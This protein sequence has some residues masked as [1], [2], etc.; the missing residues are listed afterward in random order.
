MPFGAIFQNPQ[1]TVNITNILKSHNQLT[2]HSKSGEMTWESTKCHLWA[3][4]LSIW[5]QNYGVQHS[6]TVLFNGLACR[7]TL[8]STGMIEIEPNATILY[9]CGLWENK[10][11]VWYEPRDI[12]HTIY[13]NEDVKKILLKSSKDIS[14]HATLEKNEVSCDKFWVDYNLELLYFSNVV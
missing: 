5:D 2:L 7:I 13:F 3:T 6:I 10:V 8:I 14:I 4:T 12:N 1:I 9:V 11:Y